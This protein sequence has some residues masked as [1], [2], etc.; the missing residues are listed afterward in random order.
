MFFNEDQYKVTK[1]RTVDGITPLIIDSVV[2][3][4]VVFFPKNDLVR[5]LLEEENTRKPNGLKMKIE[6][7]KG[8]NPQDIHVIQRN[9]AELLKEK[10][11]LLEKENEELK[12]GTVLKN[13]AAV[14]GSGVSSGESDTTNLASEPKEQKVLAA[15]PAK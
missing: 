2:Q 6:I 9:E 3:T 8:Y 14:N 7:A 4:K 12:A 1:V 5:K 13:S 10:I 15:K 11:A